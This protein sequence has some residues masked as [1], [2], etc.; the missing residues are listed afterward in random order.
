M[1]PNF[2]CSFAAQ[3]RRFCFTGT[4]HGTEVRSRILKATGTF[5]SLQRL[6]S[7]RD[8]RLGT[9]GLVHKVAVRMVL[10][11]GWETCPLNISDDE[12][13]HKYPRRIARIRY[14]DRVRK[15]KVRRC[16]S[17]QKLFQEAQQEDG[18]CWVTPWKCR[19]NVYQSLCWRRN[20]A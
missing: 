10:L 7:R 13:D 3:S 11:Y 1:E 8:L 2:T 4:G 12:S 6:W 5:T 18:N 20:R 15:D 9:E 14:R 16:G 19:T 17:E